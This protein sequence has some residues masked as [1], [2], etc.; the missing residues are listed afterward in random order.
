MG[1]LHI[2]QRVLKLAERPDLWNDDMA[3]VLFLVS[4]GLYKDDNH[5]DKLFA[6]RKMTDF[7]KQLRAL[8]HVQD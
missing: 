1:I 8:W 2:L 3:S 7:L 4:A 5:H 6:V